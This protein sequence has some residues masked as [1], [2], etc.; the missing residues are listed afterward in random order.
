MNREQAVPA[1]GPARRP[2]EFVESLLGSVVEGVVALLILAEVAILLTGVVS[3]YVFEEPIVWCDA[4]ASTL[5]LW[6]A[7]PG[8]A[9]ALRRNVH[10]A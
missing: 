4:L 8:A 9:V 7:M 1:I 3:R 6:L 5:F 2:A 10:C